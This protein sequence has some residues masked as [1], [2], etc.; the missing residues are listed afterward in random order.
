[1]SSDR[2]KLRSLPSVERVVQQLGPRAPH[3]TMVRV[4]RRAIEEARRLI[5]SGE[6]ADEHAIV[7][8]AAE[9]VT[10]TQRSRLQPVINATGVLIHTNLGRVPLSD[11]QLDAV[12]TV[13][14]DYS[15]LEY[16]IDRGQRGDRYENATEILCEVTG[17]EAALVV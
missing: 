8:R 9:L 1:M 11:E 10:L 7:V 13:S 2:D 14:S 4:A 3:R 5:Y 6:T 16:D 12:T 15:N 17:A